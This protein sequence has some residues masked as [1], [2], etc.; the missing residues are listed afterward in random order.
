MQKQKLKRQ[1]CKTPNYLLEKEYVYVTFT[2]A[3]HIT[4]QLRPRRKKKF[5][6]SRFIFLQ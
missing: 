5:L 2:S 6:I 4:R 1:N 3:T